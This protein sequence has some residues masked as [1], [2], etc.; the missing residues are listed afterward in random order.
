MKTVVYFL[1]Q[2]SCYC[3]NPHNIL[4][5]LIRF[6]HLYGLAYCPF[7]GY[8]WMLMWNFLLCR[9]LFADRPCTISS[10][11]LANIFNG[12]MVD[13]TVS[14][15]TS[16]SYDNSSSKPMSFQWGACGWMTCLVVGKHWCEIAFFVESCLLIILAQTLLIFFNSEDPQIFWNLF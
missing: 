1:S 14:I 16:T 7:N 13:F 10:V 3:V 8:W 12:G 9:K 5:T 11:K 4:V 2:S 15:I 6:Q